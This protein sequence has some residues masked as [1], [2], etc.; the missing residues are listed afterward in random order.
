MQFV[1]GNRLNLAPASYGSALSFRLCSM[2]SS[3]GLNI[4]LSVV[5]YGW[6]SANALSAL[7]YKL[8]KS[9]RPIAPS[10]VVTGGIFLVKES[11]EE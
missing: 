9:S 7:F 3:T 6:R 4:S 2:R 5:H 11:E 1:L 10:K 8:F